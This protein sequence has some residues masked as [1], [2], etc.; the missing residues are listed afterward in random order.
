VDYDL[1]LRFNDALA[2]VPEEILLTG[3]AKALLIVI[4]DSMADDPLWREKPEAIRGAQERAI[5]NF[6]DYVAYISRTWQSTTVTAVM[7][8]SALPNVVHDYCPP[9]RRPS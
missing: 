5:H 3:Q 7:L 8:L 6:P 1:S 4:I 2:R 9:F